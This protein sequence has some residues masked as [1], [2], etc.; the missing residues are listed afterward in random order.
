M[1]ARV[2]DFYDELSGVPEGLP[3]EAKRDGVECLLLAQS[4]HFDPLNQCPFS[5]VKQTEPEVIY[6]SEDEQGT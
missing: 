6:V 5:G 1:N 3:R 2:Q 4:R